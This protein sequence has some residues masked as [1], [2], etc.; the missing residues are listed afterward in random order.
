MFLFYIVHE[1]K[2]N[3]EINS[4]MLKDLKARNTPVISHS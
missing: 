1:I 2:I 4:K 3:K